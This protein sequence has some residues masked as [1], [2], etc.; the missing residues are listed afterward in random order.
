MHVHAA[1]PQNIM[2]NSVHLYA[3]IDKITEIDF[4]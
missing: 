1:I 2:L 4:E 3:C